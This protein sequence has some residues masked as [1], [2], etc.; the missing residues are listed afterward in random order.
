MSRITKPIICV[1]L[2]ALG[3]ISVGCSANGAHYRV[4]AAEFVEA[5]SGPVAT[6]QASAYIGCTDTHA[7]L[8]V[9]DGMPRWLGGGVHIYS[10]RIEELPAADA[11]TIRSG[12]N[13]WAR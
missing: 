5:T 6:M 2:I 13:P 12:G 10:V 11:A 9:W 4:D 3:A 7:F 1:A 8:E